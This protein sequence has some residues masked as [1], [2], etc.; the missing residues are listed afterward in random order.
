[1]LVEPTIEGAL[2]LAKKIDDQG[3][4]MQTLIPG[5][6]YPVGGALHFLEPQSS[7]S[8]DAAE[9]TMSQVAT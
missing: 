9:R 5:S 2:E 1:M 8:I 3:N 7:L 6:L 4:G